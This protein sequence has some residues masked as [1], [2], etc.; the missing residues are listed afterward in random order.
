[1]EAETF[2]LKRINKRVGV[3][4]TDICNSQCQNGKLRFGVFDVL[5]RKAL[6]QK[7]IIFYPVLAK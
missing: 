3:I 4:L 6:P 2:C 5:L 1:M 7:D